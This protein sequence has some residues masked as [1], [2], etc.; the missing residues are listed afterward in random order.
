VRQ[1]SLFFTTINH[2]PGI[3]NMLPHHPPTA[4]LNTG[5]QGRGQGGL[6]ALGPHRAHRPRRLRPRVGRRRQEV[7]VA[8]R[9]RE[10][11]RFYSCSCLW[12]RP[13]R[14]PRRDSSSRAGA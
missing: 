14:A 2:S 9:R 3:P 11:G 1:L 10:C 13:V 5:V 8:Q 4:P 7:Q 12:A 6:P